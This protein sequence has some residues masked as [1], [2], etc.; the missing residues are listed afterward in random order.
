MI[1]ERPPHLVTII[2]NVA[3]P[4]PFYNI[5]YDHGTFF[6]LG[7]IWWAEVLQTQAS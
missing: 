2:P 4:D 6:L 5:P 3:P 1:A 7:A